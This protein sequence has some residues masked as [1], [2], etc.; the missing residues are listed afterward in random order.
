MSQ[1]QIPGLSDDQ[2]RAVMRG[3]V[4][5][6]CHQP[7][8]LMSL[9]VQSCALHAAELASRRNASL[10]FV[11]TDYDAAGDQR[12]RAPCIGPNRPSSEE[13][14][15]LSGAIRRHDR[16]KPANQVNLRPGISLEWSRRHRSAVNT[17]RDA[18]GRPRLES[19]RHFH[20]VEEARASD[21]GILQTYLDL[22]ERGL[23]DLIVA[24][25]SDIWSASYSRLLASLVTD[26]QVRSLAE[27]RGLWWLCTSCCERI[28][29]LISF[30][31]GTVVAH[32]D[33]CAVGG[34]TSF[35]D[36]DPSVWLPRAAL[37]NYSD[38][39]M[40]NARDVVLYHRSE[41]HFE[42]IAGLIGL[43]SW[44]RRH[45]VSF[46]GLECPRGALSPE[47]VSA[48]ERGRFTA[49][50]YVDVRFEEGV[51][52]LNQHAAKSLGVTS[53]GP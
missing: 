33:A 53:H 8:L 16:E 7:N 27:S 43:S 9:A 39:T 12:F 35:S 2:A 45:Y 41:E 17:Y 37:C 18:V 3:D 38:L 30:A 44:T 50:F 34:S 26:Q 22:K 51:Q 29:A 4:I 36:I 40:W 21:A 10:V 5:L 28:P 11:A 15:Y 6:W 52:T 49:A 19:E 47:C 31:R 48:W 25:A 32:C 46:S 1:A 42:P 13:C 24:R 20:F 14:A 23:N